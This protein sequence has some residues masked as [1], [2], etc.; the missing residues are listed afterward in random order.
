MT[1][2][3]IVTF[4]QLRTLTATF[5]PAVAGLVVVHRAVLAALLAALRRGLGRKRA[6]ANRCRQNRNQNFRVRLHAPNFAHNQVGRQWKD[7]L[8]WFAHI[9]VIPSPAPRGPRDFVA[10]PFF[11]GSLSPSRT[12]IFLETA[13]PCRLP[14]GHR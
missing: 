8:G 2:V 10:E 11:P 12:G 6:R 3:A 13:V 5:L 7:S 1:A 4:Y 9:S 14:H